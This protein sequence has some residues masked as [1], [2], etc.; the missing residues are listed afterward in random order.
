MGRKRNRATVSDV[1]SH[2]RSHHQG[3]FPAHDKGRLPDQGE[4][5]WPEHP[6]T[7]MFLNFD[8]R[9]RRSSAFGT[10]PGDL[11]PIYLD[12]EVYPLRRSYARRLTICKY[13][14]G[15]FA[16]RCGLPQSETQPRREIIRK[17]QW[18]PMAGTTAPP[19]ADHCQESGRYQRVATRGIDCNCMLIGIRLAAIG[20]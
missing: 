18:R 13:V 7:G 20:R 4:D 2:C 14:T 5:Q 3:Q 15:T 6:P 8:A 16:S 10:T 17:S 9:F 1:P 19:P 11:D 12:F